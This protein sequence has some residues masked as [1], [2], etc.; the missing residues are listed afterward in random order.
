MPDDAQLHRY[1]QILE[2]QSIRDPKDAM[3]R[4]N[5]GVAYNQLGEPEKAIA[6]YRSAIQINPNKWTPYYNLG[7]T[8]LETGAPQE[9]KT[10]FEH[11]TKLAPNFAQGFF[12]LGTAFG[13]LGLHEQLI[14]A[15]RKG[16]QIEPDDAHALLNI[17]LACNR[18]GRFAEAIE[19]LARTIALD[20][21]NPMGYL[22]LGMAVRSIGPSA[23]VART[24]TDN[25]PPMPAFF[26]GKD[27]EQE[28]HFAL[29]LLAL[30]HIELAKSRLAQFQGIAP[31]LAGELQGFI[32]H[33]G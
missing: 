25:D 10:E 28:F 23:T 32:N 15:T 8:L 24:Q 33:E 22:H 21:E 31:E 1:V 26:F 3:A 13:A 27:P 19:S 2:E 16:L 18:L 6:A 17:G 7:C 9:A 11:L 4:Y 14:E 5:L 20:P 29:A 30:G 12:M